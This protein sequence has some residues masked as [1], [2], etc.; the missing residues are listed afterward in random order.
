MV[1]CDHQSARSDGIRCNPADGV[2]CGYV[3][4]QMCNGPMYD[5]DLCPL[6]PVPNVCM[7]GVLMLC[8][9]QHYLA[10]STQV[11]QHVGHFCLLRCKRVE[12][13]TSTK[14]RYQALKVDLI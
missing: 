3:R 14:T 10:P 4:A 6:M 11:T 7:R 2:K 5:D 9:R 1:L 8:D 12:T 13:S